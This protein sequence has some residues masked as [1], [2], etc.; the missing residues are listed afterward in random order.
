MNRVLSFFAAV[1]L[2]LPVAALAAEAPEDTVKAIV[3]KLNS[4]GDPAVVLDYVSWD[5]AFKDTPHEVLMSLGVSDAAGLKAQTARLMAEPGK[6]VREKMVERISSL[7]P[8]QQAMMN[9]QLDSLTAKVE[10]E[11]KDM[12]EKLKRTEFAVGKSTVT[13]DSAVVDI[14]ASIDGKK[15]DSQL[16]LLKRNDKWLLASPEFGKRERAPKQGAAAGPGANM[17]PV[18]PQPGAAAPAGP[19]AAVAA[20]DK[21]AAP[22]V[23]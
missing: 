21:Q 7:P 11:F 9:A 16:K 22:P 17:S 10:N 15:Q 8:E 20:P 2:L 5:D 13:G 1:F 4:S 18:N 3:G 12:K 19:P 14:S 6:Y 23:H